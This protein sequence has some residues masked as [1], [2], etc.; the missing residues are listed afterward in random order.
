MKDKYNFSRTKPKD[1]AFHRSRTIFV[2]KGKDIEIAPANIS[3][4]HL[5]WFESMGWVNEDNAEKFLNKNI[6]GLYYPPNNSLYFF[7]KERFEFDDNLIVE[8]KERLSELR[9]L[10]NLNDETQINFG[11]VD[12]II[13][14]K[15]YRQKTIGKLKDFL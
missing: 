2:F 14:G 5:E 9:I 6:R 3:M 7:R 11:P 13:E 1:E 4:S 12:K 10:L 15:E 8:T